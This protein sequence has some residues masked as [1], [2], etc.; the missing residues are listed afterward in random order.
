M[1]MSPRARVVLVLVLVIVIVIVVLLLLLLSF[2][3]VLLSLS[4][5]TR[6]ICLFDFPF[7]VL[8]FFKKLC[9]R[10]YSFESFLFTWMV[11]TH[12]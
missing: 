1:R 7:Y 10:Y 3:T 4:V 12:D 9:K 11:D 5:Q 2:V 6:E 8:F